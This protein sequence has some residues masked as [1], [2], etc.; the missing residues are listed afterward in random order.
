[1]SQQDGSI[2]K[3]YKLLSGEYEFCFMGNL[4]RDLDI[5]EIS[6]LSQGFEDPDNDDTSVY[7]S[8]IEIT[9]DD[10]DNNSGNYNFFLNALKSY[11]NRFPFNYESV[12]YLL[13]KK[14]GVNFFKGYLENVE[15]D[16]KEKK[17]VL[18]FTDG[19]SKLKN[20]NLS[21][22][23]FLEYL[24]NKQ[25]IPRYEINLDGELKGYQYGFGAGIHSNSENHGHY[26]INPGT[27]LGQE[28]NMNL[29]LFIQEMFRILNPNITV[30]FDTRT[31]FSDDSGVHQR[32][33]TF[34]VIRKILSNLLGRYLVLRLDV[35]R[36][37][38]DVWRPPRDDESVSQYAK[39]FL[40]AFEKV[41]EDE[42]YI[43]LYHN[44]GGPVL[45]PSVNIHEIPIPEYFNQGL[46]PLKLNDL[47][48]TLARNFFC[49]YS[50]SSCEKVSW[51]HKR[52]IS[53]AQELTRI[54]SLNIIADSKRTDFVKVS[55]AY[56]GV[57]S[58]SG[59]AGTNAGLEDINKLEFS[60]PFTATAAI[61]NEG[62]RLFFPSP[63]LGDYMAPVAKMK[64]QE[65][66]D[67]NPNP[68]YIQQRIATSERNKKDAGSVTYEIEVEG[69]EYDFCK[70]YKIISSDS[71]GLPRLTAYIQP[72]MLEKNLKENKTKITGVRI[73]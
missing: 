16:V 60:I 68:D 53:N 33:F 35:A 40:Y 39:D 61:Y 30:D 41:Y 42:H 69:V 2:V 6:E 3:K 67:S 36:R 14:D 63:I 56:N 52:Y 48:K 20:V 7:P 13:I 9:I 23:H 28:K 58:S 38:L 55:D 44:W 47:L 34:L 54:N 57:E 29:A 62:S 21:D 8:G 49:S 5:F 45:P 70:T 71:N 65:N 73:K 32:G 12:F 22:P 51:R 43:T 59:H 17:V 11:N 15:R 46:G 1:M 37:I 64:D 25:I 66:E 31:L 27:V 18:R 4:A 10:F 50:F 72:V 19:I 24:Y 26:F